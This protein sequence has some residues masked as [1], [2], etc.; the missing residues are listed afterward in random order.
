MPKSVSVTSEAAQQPPA[1]AH[2]VKQTEERR[3]GDSDY[4]FTNTDTNYAA[5]H[6]STLIYTDIYCLH[7]SPR[8]ELPPRRMRRRGRG[9]KLVDVI[10]DKYFPKKR[11]F[12]G[13]LPRTVNLLHFQVGGW[14]GVWPGLG[15]GGGSIWCPLLKFPPKVIIQTSGWD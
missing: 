7:S 3:G 8:Q 9:R 14:S 4:C 15:L 2:F 10:S 1:R 11:T 5:L 13:Y 6:H 12:Q